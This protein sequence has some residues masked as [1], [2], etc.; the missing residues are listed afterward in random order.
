MEDRRSAAAELNVA[1][2]LRLLR[3]PRVIAMRT[4]D[5]C[6]CGRCI[7]LRTREGIAKYSGG[8]VIG[9]SAGAWVFGK[10]CFRPHCQSGH[11]VDQARAD[12]CKL[13]RAGLRCGVLISRADPSDDGAHRACPASRLPVTVTPSDF[14]GVTDE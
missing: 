3:R 13:M 10:N 2:L 14:Q 8:T 7:C 6:L 5:P 9:C 4:R 1:I 11:G 12:L